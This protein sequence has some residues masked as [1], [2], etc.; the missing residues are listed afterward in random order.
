MFEDNI[1]DEARLEYAEMQKRHHAEYKEFWEKYDIK[2]VFEYLGPTKEQYFVNEKC[3]LCGEKAWYKIAEEPIGYIGHGL[4]QVVCGECFGGIF[5]H[6]PEHEWMK[7]Q[8]KGL[9][10]TR[11]IF[12][13]S[14]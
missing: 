13:E 9:K 3:C 8:I 5:I 6:G 4:S 12:R 11:D 7:D 14:E 2:N 1:P 10:I